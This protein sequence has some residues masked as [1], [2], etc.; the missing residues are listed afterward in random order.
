ML[1][2]ILRSKHIKQREENNMLP[3]SKMLLRNKSKNC[4]HMGIFSKYL[5]HSL[6][7]DIENILLLILSFH[8]F[9]KIVYKKLCLVNKK[10]EVNVYKQ[11][12]VLS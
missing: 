1:L 10:K 4:H 7:T 9:K 8:L 11:N 5:L 6:I 3:Y 12:E 2:V